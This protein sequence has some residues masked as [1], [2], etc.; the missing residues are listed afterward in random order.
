MYEG[1]VADSQTNK[2]FIKVTGGKINGA[3]EVSKAAVLSISGGY[4]TTDPSKYLATSTDAE[5][6]TLLRQL[7]AITSSMLNWQIK[8]TCR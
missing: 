4:F 3:L 8:M 7:P 6:S 1:A 2:A 5:K